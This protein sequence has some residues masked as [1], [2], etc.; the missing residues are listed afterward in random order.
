MLIQP[1]HAQLVDGI[2][3]Y[4]HT[5]GDRYCVSMHSAVQ[6]SHKAVLFCIIYFAAISLH[7]KTVGK[8]TKNKG[9]WQTF[10]QY[11]MFKSMMKNS[12]AVS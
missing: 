9:W 10:A 6:I 4:T 7:F 2:T 11:C 1:T 12:E 8:D 5:G 3:F